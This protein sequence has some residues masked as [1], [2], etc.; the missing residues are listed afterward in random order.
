LLIWPDVC[1]PHGWTSIVNANDTIRPCL[2]VN[3]GDSGIPGMVKNDANVIHL[4]QRSF[5]P[6]Y[7]T[8]P[9]VLLLVGQPCVPRNPR[10]KAH[11]TSHPGSNCSQARSAL[12]N[13]LEGRAR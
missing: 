3:D 10:N 4:A 7:V 6:V 13:N 11:A 1:V 5:P 8:K 12:L 9:A 2:P